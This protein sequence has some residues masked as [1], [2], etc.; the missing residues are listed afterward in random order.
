MLAELDEVPFISCEK[1]EITAEAGQTFL[2]LDRSVRKD[3]RNQPT[4][5]PVLLHELL[6]TPVP[7][8]G[9]ISRLLL[10]DL[11]LLDLF[12]LLLQFL[13]LLLELQRQPRNE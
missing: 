2:S 10:R 7:P 8:G 4:S 6:Q 12:S 9:H 11:K 5:S 3:R 1:I 13:S